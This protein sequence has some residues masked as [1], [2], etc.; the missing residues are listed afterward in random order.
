MKNNTKTH[1]EDTQD[2]S[3]EGDKYK[4]VSTWM[5]CSTKIEN[6]KIKGGNEYLLKKK[7]EKKRNRTDS[8]LL[9]SNNKGQKKMK[10]YLQIGKRK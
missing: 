3:L 1:T 8:R 2:L 9:T 4:L 5:N 7:K 6:L 10:S